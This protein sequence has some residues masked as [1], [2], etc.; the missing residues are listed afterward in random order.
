MNFSIEWNLQMQYVD[1]RLKENY[2]L[3]VTEKRAIYKI[4][5]PN[6][7]WYI[8]LTARLCTKPLK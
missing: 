2:I 1:V 4:L 8:L 3:K 6:D 5:L 7:I